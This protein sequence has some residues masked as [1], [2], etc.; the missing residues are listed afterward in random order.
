MARHL[1]FFVG[2]GVARADP[3][4]GSAAK[5]WG[6]VEELA[7]SQAPLQHC[8]QLH[9][10]A[11]VA[12]LSCVGW[13]LDPPSTA[14]AKELQAIHELRRAA[15]NS[16]AKVPCDRAC[17]GPNFCVADAGRW[18]ASCWR[19]STTSNVQRL[20][21]LLRA[22]RRLAARK[23][24]MAILNRHEGKVGHSKS[25]HIPRKA[26]L[27]ALQER[28]CTDTIALTIRRRLLSWLLRFA[29]GNSNRPLLF[30]GARFPG[31]QLGEQLARR[32]HDP[33]RALAEERQNRLRHRAGAWAAMWIPDLLFEA[34]DVNNE[35]DLMDWCVEHLYGMLQRDDPQA[36][37]NPDAQ[38]RRLAH[39]MCR[40]AWQDGSFGRGKLELRLLGNMGCNDGGIREQAA[41]RADL[42]ARHRARRR[43]INHQA[44]LPTNPDEAEAQHDGVMD[45]EP[46]D[47]LDTDDV[48]GDLEAR[49]LRLRAHL[50][51]LPPAGLWALLKSLVGGLTTSH[52]MHALAVRL[53]T[54]LLTRMDL[55][56]AHGPK[57]EKGIE[58][59][60]ARLAVACRFCHMT[61]KTASQSPRT[62]TQSYNGIC[63]ARHSLR[64]PADLSGGAGPRSAHII[65]RTCP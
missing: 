15:P 24:K 21:G 27:L 65:E 19:D 23:G 7:A 33:A 58:N 18:C 8:I 40:Q 11:A 64:L 38:R 63:A 1:G 9:S 57:G 51:P 61:K 16:L 37:H 52:R 59:C 49:W 14:H 25:L 54:P 41:L 30:Q 47:L 60:M 50:A 17:R 56:D 22:A 6:R 2:P 42:A 5:R 62:Y 48:P 53:A 12:R 34:R 26:D 55:G 35:Q 20:T 31:G 28:L 3:W 43:W 39:D 44:L 32:P 46:E 10:V 13:L 45:V 4:K 36:L 29:E